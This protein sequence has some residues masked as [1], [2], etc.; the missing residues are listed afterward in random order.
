[1]PDLDVI[2]H[3]I[4]KKFSH[5]RISGIKQADHGQPHQNW[6]M[7]LDKVQVKVVR[8][9]ADFVQLGPIHLDGREDD[10]GEDQHGGEVCLEAGERVLANL[11]DGELLEENISLAHRLHFVGLLELDSEFYDHENQDAENFKV[12]LE[13]VREGGKVLRVDVATGVENDGQLG[14]QGELGKV[15]DEAK[16]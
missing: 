13:R 1:L 5:R 16:S 3:F 6:R 15:E 7:Q 9:A 8:V 11:L 10:S 4:E 12:A 14:V 2:F